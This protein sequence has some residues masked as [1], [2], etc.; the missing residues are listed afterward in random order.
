MAQYDTGPDKGLT[1]GIEVIDEPIEER[2]RYSGSATSLHAMIISRL[3]ARRRLSERSVNRRIDAW[4]RVDEHCRLFIDLSRKVRNADGSNETDKYEMPWSRSIVVPM[5]YAILQV[6]LTQLMGIY[7]RRDPPIEIYG[8]G[9]ED[10]RPAKL[11]NA[12]IAY[13]QVQTNYVLELYT[14]I[15]DAMKY[16]HGGFHDAW[17]EEHGYIV[18][19]ANPMASMALKMF[20]LPTAKRVWGKQCEYNGVKA[21]DP[22]SFFPDPRVSLSDMQYG[23]FVGH[24]LWRGYL[25]LC[26]ESQE[27]GGIYFNTDAIARLSPKPQ[28]VR[29]RNRFQV[30]QMNLTGSMDE[31]D[32]GFHAVDSMMV[33][34][35]PYDWKVGPSTRPEKWHFTWVDDQVII[36]AHPSDYEHDDF[37]Y[38]AFE[39]NIDTHVFGNQG[40]VEN[41][42][43]LQRFMT[44]IYNSHIQNQIRFLN[45]RMIYDEQLIE[46]FDVENP[47]AALHIRLTPLGSQMLKEGRL[48]I[49]QMFM[50]LQLQDVTGPLVQSVNQMFDFAMRMSGA[51]DQMMGRTTSEKRTLG[52]VQRVGHEGSARMAM[53]AGMMD[54]QGLRPLALRW[55]SNRQQYTQEDQYV[56][57]A[58]DLAAEFGGER[59]K[60]RPYDLYGNYDYL[61][62]TGPEPPN[63]EALADAFMKGLGM[64]TQSPEIL[65]VPDKDGKILDVHAWIKETVRNL[66]IKNVNEFYKAM[67]GQPG[68]Q[69]PGAGVTVMPDEQLA[70]EQQ[71]GNVIPMNRAA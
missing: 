69:M 42:D 23:E 13:D 45:N 5:S 36:R 51:A 32:R 15:Q 17:R 2:L 4:N 28:A 64:I 44:W 53:H 21:W 31:K 49:Q 40:S 34:L 27:N 16:G 18:K 61:P 52:E 19:R 55:C 43:G 66:G 8:I 6:Y 38:S 60:V 41:L 58:G 67:G 59:A 48:S 1:A 50:Q 25:E 33:N 30:S 39:S 7:T 29:S 26:A 47:D 9:P 57:I 46:G 71:R 37:N 56:R 3:L 62:K 22:Y 11:M 10:V 54:A 68:Q 12:V 20:G 65:A 70:M 35:I 63:Q 24:R 14:A